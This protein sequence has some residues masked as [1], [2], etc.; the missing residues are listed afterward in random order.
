MK[1]L[2]QGI[3]EKH[4]ENLA[5]GKDIRSRVGRFMGKITN[6][7]WMR[8]YRNSKAERREE[9][10]RNKQARK[11]RSNMDYNR[12]QIAK[13]LGYDVKYFTEENY[14]R[15][16]EEAKRQKVRLN[17]RGD[18]SKDGA[19][20]TDKD[21]ERKKLLSRSTAELAAEASQSEDVDLRQL[22]EQHQTN[23]YLKTIAEKFDITI[24]EARAMYDELAESRE[25]DRARA[26]LDEDGNY[27]GGRAVR[28]RNREKRK[29][30]KRRAR[31]DRNNEENPEEITEETPV[32]EIRNNTS[33]S[34][35]DN[36]DEL[37]RVH[38]T[39]GAL[40][41]LREYW[42]QKEERRL[43][44]TRSAS[45]KDRKSVV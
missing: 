39:E 12:S 37:S 20:E 15:A 5:E 2:K 31:E 7:P 44:D 1:G 13:I 23:E 35:E 16:K 6:D 8:D 32:A 40:N 17:I 19:F 28:Q 26:G 21:A 9:L 29:E 3:K 4:E 45:Q 10:N 33:Q 30:E 14:E 18:L 27:I 42:R 25:D 22:S 36:S 24:D 41:E 38:D 43:N 34:E 11:Q